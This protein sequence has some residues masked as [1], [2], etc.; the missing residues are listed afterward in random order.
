MGGFWCWDEQ[1]CD[2]RKDKNPELMSSRFAPDNMNALDG[3][4]NQN[5]TLN[6]LFWNSNQVFAWYC[7]SD[8]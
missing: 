3:M 8:G 4:F 5:K 6:P 2:A 7:S 1:S